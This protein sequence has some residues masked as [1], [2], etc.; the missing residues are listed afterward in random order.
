MS[1]VV[2]TNRDP[3]RD[4]LTL[5]Y[6]THCTRWGYCACVLHTHRNGGIKRCYN[7]SCYLIKHGTFGSGSKWLSDLK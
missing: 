7:M 3:N 5:F 2:N 6:L 1:D 4:G